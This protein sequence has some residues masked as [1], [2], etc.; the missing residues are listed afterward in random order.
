LAQRASGSLEARETREAELTP[1]R[2]PDVESVRALLREEEDLVEAADPDTP[3][4]DDGTPAGRGRSPRR[5]WLR[6]GRGRF[7]RRRRTS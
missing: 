7:R 5:R 4:E 1:R 3:A 2:A 6:R